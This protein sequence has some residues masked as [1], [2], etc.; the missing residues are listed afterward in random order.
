[1]NKECCKEPLDD[2]KIIIPGEKSSISICG[3]TERTKG[4]QISYKAV[5]TEKEP[6]CRIR[7]NREKRLITDRQL[8]IRVIMH[9]G[10]WCIN[11]RHA[12]RVI[13]G[14]SNRVR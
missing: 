8:V 5:I 13:Q 14:Y 2:T 12:E 6:L 7:E 9:E 1:M 11:V 4:D 10:E 3:S